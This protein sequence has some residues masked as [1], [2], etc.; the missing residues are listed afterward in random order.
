MLKIKRIMCTLLF[1]LVLLSPETNLLAEDTIRERV[2]KMTEAD[3]QEEIKY[4]EME[5]LAQ[6]VQAEAGNQDL[7]GMRYVAAVVLNRVDSDIFPDTVE[8]VIFQENQFSVIKDGGFDRAGWNMSEQ[9]Y[10]AV[11]LEYESRS[12]YEILYFSQGKSEYMRNGTFKYG[13]HWF[14]W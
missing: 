9:A 4:G 7:T 8:E 2:P 1:L 12:N 10:E 14:G 13:D 11:R 5:L 6:L 3:I